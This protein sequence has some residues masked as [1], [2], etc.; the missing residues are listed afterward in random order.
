MGYIC[1][2]RYYRPTRCLPD[3]K[4]RLIIAKKVTL[5]DLKGSLWQRVIVSESR[6]LE[7]K[8]P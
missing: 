2:W 3:A 4:T 1:F 5:K 8:E 7:K 6:G